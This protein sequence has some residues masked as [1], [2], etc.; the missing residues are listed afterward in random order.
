M[1][2]DL[3]IL[4]FGDQIVDLPDLQ[5]PHPLIAEREFVLKPLAGIA[6]QF[7][8]PLTGR[9]IAEMLM[10]LEIEGEAKAISLDV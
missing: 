10:A 7:R 4:F 6:P 5:I 2:I 8:H 3:D 1:A 9:T